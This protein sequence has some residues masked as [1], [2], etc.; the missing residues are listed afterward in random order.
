MRLK[1]YTPAQARHKA[2]MD[3][4]KSR[5]RPIPGPRP[6]TPEPRPIGAKERARAAKRVVAMRASRPAMSLGQLRV[7]MF[8]ART[9]SELRPPDLTP[10]P[11]E[12]KGKPII[13][14]EEFEQ[15]YR[16]L[17]SP[18]ATANALSL[19]PGSVSRRAL[20][21]GLREQRETSFAG[22]G[23]RQGCAEHSTTSR[24]DAEGEGVS[25]RDQEAGDEGHR[26]HEAAGSAQDREEGRQGHE[27][28][29]HAAGVLGGTTERPGS[30]EVAG[31]RP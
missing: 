13:T 3:L 14:A 22:S 18:K 25:A 2:R 6:H 10:V 5:R 8:R 21:H 30:H 28:Q 31:A 15:A 1:P 9:R 27:R 24:D 16:E 20:R 4:K 7:A 19:T 17:G 12:P 11:E 26:Q 23:P 29:A